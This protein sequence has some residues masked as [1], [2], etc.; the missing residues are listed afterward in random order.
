MEPVNVLDILLRCFGNPGHGLDRF[1]RI[2]SCSGL[3]RQHDSTGAV[4]DC[5][6]HIGS[7]GTCGTWI[8][9]HGFQHLCRGNDS[10]AEHAAFCDQVFLDGRKLLKGDLNAHVTAGDHD[11]V[12]FFADLLDIVAA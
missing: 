2:F 5:V 1:D 4:I 9:D 11:P 12:A 8:I 6:C 3:S 10:F 7:L